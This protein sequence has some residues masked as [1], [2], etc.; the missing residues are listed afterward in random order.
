ME[1]PPQHQ[2]EDP[3]IVNNNEQHVAV[4]ITAPIAE[5]V[6]LQHKVTTALILEGRNPEVA[7]PKVLDA[8]PP[9]SAPVVRLQETLLAIDRILLVAE[10]DR[11]LEVAE[12][13]EQEALP[14]LEALAVDADN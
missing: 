7:I 2:E 12:V 6:Y 11:I 3:L 4:A 14:Q 9:H 1:P 8:R 10:A 5:V 13:Q